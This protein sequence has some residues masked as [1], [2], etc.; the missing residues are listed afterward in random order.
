MDADEIPDERRSGARGKTGK[1]RRLIILKI[2]FGPI[3]TILRSFVDAT[4]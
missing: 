4:Y 1:I 3:N 2:I